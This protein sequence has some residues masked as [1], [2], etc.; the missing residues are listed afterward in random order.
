MPSLVGLDPKYFIAAMKAY[1][2]GERKHEM[3]KNFAAP[4]AEP[5]LQQHRA[6]LRAAEPARAPTPASG[7]AAAG[8]KAPPRAAAAMARAA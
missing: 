7:D 4:L 1:K 8:K 3:M 6:L 5:A 2:T